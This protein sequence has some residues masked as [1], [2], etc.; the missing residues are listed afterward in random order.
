MR[1]GGDEEVEISLA[2]RWEEAS[3]QR[4]EGLLLGINIS[5]ED[6]VAMI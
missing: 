4:R 3:A 2:E 5:V 1:N 6:V